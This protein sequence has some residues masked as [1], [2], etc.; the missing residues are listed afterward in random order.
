[1]L[2]VLGKPAMRR[3]IVLPELADLLDLPAA[4]RLARPL[5]FGVGSESLG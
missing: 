5:V 2:V 1:M 4:H 3:S